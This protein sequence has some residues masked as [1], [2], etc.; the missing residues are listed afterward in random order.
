MDSVFDC[1]VFFSVWFSWVDF[2]S[3]CTSHKSLS[4]LFWSINFHWVK[5]PPNI[6]KFW[7][8]A[9]HLLHSVSECKPFTPI[10]LLCTSWLSTCTCMCHSIVRHFLKLISQCLDELLINNTS[11]F[12][13]FYSKCYQLGQFENVVHYLSL[14]AEKVLIRFYR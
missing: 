10:N 13:Y 12:W 14:Q 4:L 8:C 11:I 1:L 6:P 9:F 2:L 3:E 5:L 7:N